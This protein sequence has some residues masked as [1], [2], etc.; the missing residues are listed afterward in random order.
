MTVPDCQSLMLPVLRVAA[1]GETKASD[2]AERIADEL[3]PTEA[4][5]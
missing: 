5:R 3:G 2:A 4:E 1:L